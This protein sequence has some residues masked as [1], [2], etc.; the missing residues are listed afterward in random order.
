MHKDLY[1]RQ[2]LISETE[3]NSLNGWQKGSIGSYHIY[4]HPDT[5]INILENSTNHSQIAL[6]GF[7]IN[8]HAPLESNLDILKQLCENVSI[9]SITKKLYHYTG[10]FVLI[11]KKNNDYSIFHDPCGLRSVFY[12]QF[13]NKLYAA[14]QPL[15]FK[16]VI[17]LIEGDRYYKYNKSKYKK[18]DN[19]HWIPCGCSL[20]ENVYQLVPNH[21]LDCKAFK[22]NRFWP[23]QKISQISLDE[24]VVKASKILKN[25][26]IAY[27]TRFK[28]ALP[29]T[30]GFDS[31]TILSAC[32]EIANDVFFYTLQYRGLNLDSG[33]LKVPRNLLS[34]LGYPHHIIDCRK[35]TDKNFAE[36]YEKNSD[37][38][39]LNDWGNFAYGMQNALPDERVVIKG[40]CTEIARCFYYKSGTHPAVES[41]ENIFNLVSGIEKVDFAK[42]ELSKWFIEIKKVEA[43]FG[44]DIF[45]MFYWE[46]RLGSWQA[47]NQLEWDIVQ[48]AATPFNNRELID[49]TLFVD[50][51]YRHKPD[52]LLYKKMMNY[53]WKETLAEPLNPVP[54]YHK[55]LVLYDI[56]KKKFK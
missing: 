32:K 52:Y 48:D 54:F 26:M 5:A 12:T 16:S 39:H 56:L 8:P 37:M 7:I 25:T 11:V 19:E 43:D 10:R 50:V 13:E 6:I 29:L 33:D 14:S 53:M 45:D 3:C 28:L 38:S 55:L 30:A 36:V 21:Y 34:R 23:N 15:L 2:F 9:E 22:Q 44:Y 46:Q 41:V 17:S 20:F 49:I 18:I 40:N 51:K 47:Q 4:V 31:R 1:R 42:D 24:A 35:P 27:N